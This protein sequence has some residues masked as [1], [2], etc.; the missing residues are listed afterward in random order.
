MMGIFGDLFSTFKSKKKP[1]D[2][3]EDYAT[4]PDDNISEQ[5]QLTLNKLIRE[6]TKKGKR[7]MVEV[8]N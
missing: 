7:K 6:R 3:D 5:D 1:D 2:E 8:E 4:N